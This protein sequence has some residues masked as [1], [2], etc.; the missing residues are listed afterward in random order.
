MATSIVELH[1]ILLAAAAALGVL[2]TVP[3]FGILMFR[4]NL[5]AD[6]LATQLGKLIAANNFDRA[7]KLCAGAPRVYCVRMLKAMLLAWQRGDHSADGLSR[8]FDDEDRAFKSFGTYRLMAVV[9]MLLGVTAAGVHFALDG[10]TDEWLF[11]LGGASVFFGLLAL[12]LTS[13]LR[14]KAVVARD[15]VLEAFSKRPEFGT[16]GS[17]GG[18]WN[19]DSDVRGQ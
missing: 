5:R 8:A 18:A 1:T 15:I 12:R 17:D 4:H 11:G 7:L 2:L 16:V 10:L 9:G 13:S 6:A 19:F 3:T 14:R